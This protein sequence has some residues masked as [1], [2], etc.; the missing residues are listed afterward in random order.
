MSIRAQGFTGR[1]ML[2]TTV[3]FFGVIITVNVTMA[4]LASSTWSGLVV[5]DTYLASQEF[6]KNAAAMKAMTASGIAGSLS[7]KGREIHYDIRN[8]NGSPAAVDDVTA[9]F[10]RP[11]GDHEDFAVA[12][13][14][15]SEGHFLADHDVATGDWIVEIVAKRGETLVMHQA[16]R[17]DTAETDQ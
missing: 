6:N 15:L 10:K 11:V 12:L 16:V 9:N 3:A 7:I 13:K 8:N 4:W 17:I 14:K 1:H 2:L 5:N